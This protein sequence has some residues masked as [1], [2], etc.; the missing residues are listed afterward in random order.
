MAAELNSGAVGAAILIGGQGRRFGG[1]KHT[2][3]VV[4]GHTAQERATSILTRVLGAAPLLIGGLEH[5]DGRVGSGPL[6]GIET[7]LLLA[8][9]PLCIV[10]A[11][12]LPGLD[13]GLLALL[14]DA[15]DDADVV[16]PAPRGQREP[17]CARWRRSAVGVVSQALDAEQRAVH[18]VMEQLVVCELD[19][20]HLQRGTADP[21]RALFNVNTREDLERFRSRSPP[22]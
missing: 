4:D 22:P 19:D 7:A 3:L 6:A 1:P 11:C 2:Q 5:P 12:D 20:A 18:R 13:A 15:P 9:W 21:E 17:L 8:P 10:V 16:V 14:R